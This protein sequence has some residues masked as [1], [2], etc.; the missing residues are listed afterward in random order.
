MPPVQGVPILER[1]YHCPACHNAYDKPNSCDKHMMKIHGMSGS[2][3]TGEGPVQVLQGMYVLL[4]PAEAP[5]AP[6][7]DMAAMEQHVRALESS[8]LP[9][10]EQDSTVSGDAEG[11]FSTR[12]LGWRVMKEEQPLAQLVHAQYT[13]ESK[14]NG[15]LKVVQSLGEIVENMPLS[16]RAYAVAPTEGAAAN[17]L[18]A[19]PNKSKQRVLALISMTV[20]ADN[21]EPKQRF[22]NV[23]Q[24]VQHVFS[25]GD[26]NAKYSLG[27]QALR[28]MIL[29]KQ[30]EGDRSKFRAQA[31]FVQSACGDLAW[32]ARVNVCARLQSTFNES[33]EVALEMADEALS[34]RCT[35]LGALR[36]I[37]RT[38]KRMQR[39]SLAGSNKYHVDYVE[40]D[41][42]YTV[43][44]TRLGADFAQ[45]LHRGLL[46]HLH[47]I[48][49]RMPLSPQLV[50][51]I[52]SMEHTM[53]ASRC[54]DS[55]VDDLITGRPSASLQLP[56]DMRAASVQLAF[57]LERF[58]SAN[59]A[60][61]QWS[62]LLQCLK[63]YAFT[64]AARMHIG[65]AAG[66][67]GTELALMT[68][69]NSQLFGM[70]SVFFQGQSGTRIRLKVMKLE[71]LSKRAMPDIDR[72]V[73][74]HDA[75]LLL[76]FLFVLRP[77]LIAALAKL[78]QLDSASASAF[79]I[80]RGA[81]GKYVPAV[82]PT[83]TR[84]FGK[85]YADT[86]RLPNINFQQ[87]RHVFSLVVVTRLMPPGAMAGRVSQEMRAYGKSLERIS[88]QVEA[89]LRA[90][91]TWAGLNNQG[92]HAPTG[93]T[94][95]GMSSVAGDIPV[96]LRVVNHCFFY[97]Y[98]SMLLPQGLLQ[99]ATPG[100]AQQPRLQADEAAH[101]AVQQFCGGLTFFSEQQRTATTKLLTPELRH[102]HL[103]LVAPTGSGKT[104]AFLA[105]ALM[106]PE[107][108]TLV[109]CPLRAL[110]HTMLQRL[111]SLRPGLAAHWKD[112]TRETRIIVACPESIDL[113]SAPLRTPFDDIVIDECQNLRDASRFR[114]AYHN[115]R[116]VIATNWPNARLVLITGTLPPSRQPQVL[117][118]MGIKDDR[119]DV[120]R[121]PCTVRRD[122][123]LR[124]DLLPSA[125][126]VRQAVSQLLAGWLTF[127]GSFARNAI[128]FCPT[129]ELCRTMMQSLMTSPLRWYNV[130]TTE[131]RVYHGGQEERH[132]DA[133]LSWWMPPTTQLSD[134]ARL[135]ICT[136][137][138]AEG[139]DKPDVSLS[140]VAHGLPTIELDLQ[141]ISRAGR[142]AN[143]Q[144]PAAAYIVLGE[145][146][147]EEA[148]SMCSEGNADVGNV[149]QSAISNNLCIHTAF[150][151]IMDGRPQHLITSLCE[152][153]PCFICNAEENLVTR[154]LHSA[155][156]QPWS[157]PASY[158]WQPQT[159]YQSPH[160]SQ[161]SSPPESLFS[162]SSSLSLT[163]SPPASQSSPTSSFDSPDKW[164]QQQQRSATLQSPSGSLDWTAVSDSI[165]ARCPICSLNGRSANHFQGKSKHWYCPKAPNC[166]LIC[167][168]PAHH[169]AANSTCKTSDFQIDRN[170]FACFSCWGVFRHKDTDG[171]CD[172]II[173][174]FLIAA[175]LELHRRNRT[176]PIP[177]DVWWHQVWADKQSRF[178]LAVTYYLELTGQERPAKAA[179]R[180]WG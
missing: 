90:T 13:Q 30:P 134:K 141:A 63:E 80:Q 105:P 97:L 149:C 150:S 9:L 3:K 39:T 2:L 136:H 179:R 19:T 133:V 178:R 152:D 137:A 118:L 166:C 145:E 7:A 15:Y 59:L 120:V 58:A 102:Q 49:D 22:E 28:L 128:I 176:T 51:R 46:Q 101:M 98:W 1:V 165:L 131:I 129:P 93:V 16:L 130:H 33:G 96:A 32:F 125:E 67:R 171:Q 4:N 6:E 65:I 84:L 24:L 158:S 124:I 23:F 153:A 163:Q 109:L 154:M 172:R 82:G 41:Q 10:Q 71:R 18:Q 60:L 47:E 139:M 156:N 107:W 79:L 116:S 180:N 64:L 50:S 95:Y 43:N 113:N 45:E 44:G 86:L 42:S 56:P 112:A 148:L 78:Q 127:P 26:I 61:E 14:F 126:A 8:S 142:Q 167:G 11:L 135:L 12:G 36:S 69:V 115:L 132:Q 29:A 144:Q 52:K 114:P 83:I 68:L 74:P 91:L 87:M 122:L 146:G 108:R 55:P 31:S 157:T 20:A 66:P 76:S 169:G 168:G 88:Q 27:E 73:H 123:S 17:A 62:R 94:Q 174:G 89:V 160:V 140:I 155:R 57:E 34:I 177:Q 81:S 100:A 99:S 121:S 103:L 151:R 77:L 111:H 85:L 75:N 106:Y 147:E 35:T 5:I 53:E 143:L 170:L 92:H 25:Q 175:N 110:V 54:I 119:L 159:S 70:R 104:A 161:Q 40:E 21:A 164:Q 138:L 48:L 37:Q 117:S 72:F 162:M 38:A 173:K